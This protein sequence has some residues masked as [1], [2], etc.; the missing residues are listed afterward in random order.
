MVRTEKTEYTKGAEN[1]KLHVDMGGCMDNRSKC[2]EGVNDD[3]PLI[4]AYWQGYASTMPPAERVVIICRKCN[5]AHPG[6][7]Y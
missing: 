4:R 1:G 7:C 6:W 2:A 5:R 3:R